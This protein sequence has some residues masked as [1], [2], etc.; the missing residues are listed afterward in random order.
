VAGFAISDFWLQTDARNRVRWL[1][2]QKHGTYGVF[3][4]P[5]GVT[6]RHHDPAWINIDTPVHQHGS[7]NRRDHDERPPGP[8]ISMARHKI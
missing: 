8:R 1:G 4:L 7:G 2:V 3:D 5:E 6:L